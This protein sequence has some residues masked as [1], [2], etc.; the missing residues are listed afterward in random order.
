MQRVAFLLVGPLFL[1]LAAPAHAQEAVVL[2]AEVSDGSPIPLGA[3]VVLNVQASNGTSVPVHL[4]VGSYF[5]PRLSVVVYREDGSATPLFPDV[6]EGLPLPVLLSEEAETPAGG[7][8]VGTF[9]L[10]ELFDIS[11]AGSYSVEVELGVGAEVV[12]ASAVFVV[13][14]P[15][16]DL[17]E[18][19]ANFFRARRADLVVFGFPGSALTEPPL[20]TYARIATDHA[21]TYLGE[22]AL[23][24]AV[25]EGVHQG[26]SWRR[27]GDADAG[28]RM[29]T[30]A[31]ERATTFL[32]RYPSSPFAE[33]V[34]TFQN[35]A[36][37][38]LGIAI[39]NVAVG[40]LCQGQVYRVLNASPQP[41]GLL[42]EATDMGE[43]FE[44]EIESETDSV[45]TFVRP[46]AGVRLFYGDRLVA[47]ASADP[48]TCSELFEALLL[49]PFDQ[50]GGAVAT[51]GAVDATF[52]GNSFTVSGSPVDLTAAVV[53]DA[54]PVHG[55]TTAAAAS[56]DAVLAALSPQQ[57]ARVT[58]LGTAPDVVAEPLP[59]DAAAFADDLAALATV[60]LDT[61]PSGPVGTE[62]APVVAYAPSGVRLSGGFRGTGV[63]VVDGSFEMRGDAEWRGLVVVRGSSDQQADPTLSGNPRIIGALLVLPGDGG[64]AAALRLS[65]QVSVLYSPEALAL[66]ASAAQQ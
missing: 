16:G 52:S 33:D 38:A 34:V 24:H 29:L 56:A 59:F 26:Y 40:S 21:D 41:V 46:V 25:V 23:Y 54:E 50:I 13:S 64:R 31:D 12:A 39:P 17:E 63:L 57:G 55:I 42:Y 22:V 14:P 30:D 44:L 35:E 47:L 32:S 18:E 53:G 28:T 4:G 58:G 11:G 5:D 7:V 36:A 48:S 3:P 45:I 10:S 61:R 20:D 51:T 65:G 19:V 1:G 43:R 8:A 37:R 62:A 49:S 9:V 60:T 27:Y 66:A 2:S 6:S 15:P